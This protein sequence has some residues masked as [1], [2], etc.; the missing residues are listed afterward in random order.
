MLSCS[1]L[2]GD[3]PL[4][5][6]LTLCLYSTRPSGETTSSLESFNYLF[7]DFVFIEPDERDVETFFK[8]R[9]SQ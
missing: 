8:L 4:G 2:S 6:H 3:T 5:L 1:A 7:K 9:K